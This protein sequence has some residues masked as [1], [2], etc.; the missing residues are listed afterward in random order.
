MNRIA[1]FTVLAVTAG[2]CPGTTEPTGPL[3][4]GTWGGEN[5]GVIVSDTSLHA[6]VGCTYGN[7]P[8]PS[9]SDGRFDVAGLYNITAHPVDAG[10]FHPAVFRGQVSGVTLTLTV[11][12]TDTDVTLGPVLVQLGRE[13]KMGPCPI[14]RPGSAPRSMK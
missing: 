12:L 8:R 6:H 3:P 9:L 7:A 2:S 1:L 13:P 10:V 5:A 4:V 11:A 14:C